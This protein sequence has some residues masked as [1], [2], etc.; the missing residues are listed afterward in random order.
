MKHFVNNREFLSN[1]QR[2]CP[3]LFR[4]GLLW[5]VE[6]VLEIEGVWVTYASYSGGRRPNPNY[7]QVCTGVLDMLKQ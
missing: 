7:E 5:G 4:F 6:R 1:I 3:K 2:V